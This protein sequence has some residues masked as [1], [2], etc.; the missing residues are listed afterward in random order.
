MAIERSLYA[1][2]QGL[3]TDGLGIDIEMEGGPIETEITMLEDGG[4]EVS[5]SPEDDTDAD[6]DMAPFDANLAEYLDSGQ[7]LELG[8][9]LLG[10]VL[11]DINFRYDWA[12]T[13]VRGL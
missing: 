11:S 9:E 3:P 10:L 1:M 2:P 4:V 7:L 5:I 6:I 8:N 12:D 13:F